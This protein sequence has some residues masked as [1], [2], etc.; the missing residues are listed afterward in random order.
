MLCAIDKARIY[1]NKHIII[2]I[3]TIVSIM[4]IYWKHNKARYACIGLLI[5]V[6]LAHWIAY[7]YASFYSD[8]TYNNGGWGGE[9]QY[10]SHKFRQDQGLANGLYTFFM[11]RKTDCILD[12]GCGNGFYIQYL[13]SKGISNVT[14]IDTYESS[15]RNP[16]FIQH[17]DLSKPIHYPADWVV[18]FEVGEHIPKQHES[19]FIENITRNAR[20]GIIMSWAEVG[21]GGDGHVNEMDVGQVV[22]KITR[23]GFKLDTTTTNV[24]RMQSRIC[25]FK[26]NL[27]VF[28]RV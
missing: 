18:T 15:Q 17:G 5:V 19:V 21:H 6:L 20:K 14:G 27:V 25:Y 10:L 23:H 26:R 1:I 13:A 8:K 12:L 28:T 24:L 7:N 3:I 4:A 16:T 11:Q 9:T 2:V 22:K